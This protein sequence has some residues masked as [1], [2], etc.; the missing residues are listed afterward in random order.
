MRRPKVPAVDW[1]STA[2]GQ[3]AYREARARAQELAN[4]LG[5]DH[6]LERN[7]LFK[8]WHVFMLPQHSNRYG[9]ETRCEV[10]MCEN[11][12]KCQPG[13]GPRK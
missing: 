2:L 6:G 8:S 11:L 7:D 12:E 4:S 3:A 9:H 10:V 5:F 1:A 13:H